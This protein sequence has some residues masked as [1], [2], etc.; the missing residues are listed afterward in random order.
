ME[1][2]IITMVYRKNTHT[3]QYLL[4]NS[5]HPLTHKLSVVRTLLDRCHSIMTENQDRVREEETIQTALGNCGYP[6]WTINKVKKTTR[7]H[8][9]QVQEK[10]GQQNGEESWTSGTALHQGTIGEN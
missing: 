8:K 7:D 3:N 1:L 2:T 6:R 10:E 5:M 4:F 9:K